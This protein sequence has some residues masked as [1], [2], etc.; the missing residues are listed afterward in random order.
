MITSKTIEIPE[1]VKEINSKIIL[2]TNEAKM[3]FVL[4]LAIKNIEMKTGGPFAAAVFNKST[5]ELVSIGLN[6]VVENNCSVAHAEVV[7]II[8]AEEKLNNYR[9]DD[10]EYILISSAQPCVMCNGALLWSGIT[11]LVFGA[12]KDDVEEIVGFDEGPI[13][14]H[15]IEEFKNRG[16]KVLGKILHDKSRQVLQLYKDSEGILY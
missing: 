13:H 4:D 1:W 9:L 16:I 12:T 5:N 15:W 2:E 6:V 7:A 8:N 3:N 11:T 10:T 14:P